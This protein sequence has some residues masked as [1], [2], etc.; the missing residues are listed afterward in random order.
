MN[1]PKVE[2]FDAWFELRD[3]L[4]L[5]ILAVGSIYMSLGYGWGLGLDRG[6][7]YSEIMLGLDNKYPIQEPISVLQGKGFHV[8]QDAFI[9][10]FLAIGFLNF[11]YGFWIKNSNAFYIGVAA[12]FVDIWLLDFLHIF[13]G[14]MLI[15]PMLLIVLFILHYLYDR[16]TT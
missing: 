4:K 16:Y 9:I 10:I 15:V 5:V 14:C 6:D 11:I 12:I 3:G 7:L 2:E 1:L 13:R 8:T